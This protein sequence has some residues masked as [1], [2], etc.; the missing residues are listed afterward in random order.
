MV[1]ANSYPMRVHGI[2]VRYSFADGF[3]D[4]F[5]DVN[6][7]AYKIWKNLIDPLLQYM[8]YSNNAIEC[9]RTKG[10]GMK[11]QGKAINL[12][13]NSGL[14]LVFVTDISSSVN[15]DTDFQSG[16]EFAQELVRTTGASKRYGP[17]THCR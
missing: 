9:N 3:E 14:D 10:A 6:T 8:C 12:N 16:L 7:T 2:I 1:I 4:R 11:I 15:K 17:M 5:K 13:A